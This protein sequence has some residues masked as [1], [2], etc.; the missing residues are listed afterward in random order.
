MKSAEIRKMASQ[1]IEELS[2]ALDDGHSE[3]LKAYLAMLDR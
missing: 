2:M 3:S 1:A